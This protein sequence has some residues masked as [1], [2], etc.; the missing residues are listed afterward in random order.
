MPLHNLSLPLGTQVEF[1]DGFILRDTPAW[2]KNDEGILGDIN[3]NDRQAT[4]AA[5]HA[6]VAEYQ[7]ASIG[8]PDA[9]WPG[10]KPKSIQELKFQ[11]AMLANLAIWLRQPS[12]AHFTVCFHALSLNTPQ[13]VVLRTE[14]HTRLFCHPKDAANPLSLNHVVKAGSLHKVLSTVPRKNALWQSLRAVWAA[15]TSYR[16]DLRYPLFWQGLESLF[17]SEDKRY[18]ITQRLRDRISTFLADSE[19]VRQQISEKVGICYE[20]RSEIVHGRWEEGPEIDHVMAD[21][22][23]IVR[24]VVRHILE[25]PGMLAIFI[26]ERRDGF[27]DQWVRSKAFTPPQFSN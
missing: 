13:P 2:V 25:K 12:T 5:K 17:G 14:S 26:S 19:S 16:A 18:G 6:L 21:T 27:L 3:R 1:G 8:E 23:A 24:T 20:T 7:A 10:D 22:E 11:S 4:L 9:K 15:L